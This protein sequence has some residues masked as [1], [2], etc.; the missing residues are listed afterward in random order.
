[1]TQRLQSWTFI[2][3]KW[4]LYIH[5]NSCTWMFMAASFQ[6]PKPGISPE[7]CLRVR[8]SI[9]RMPIQHQQ[10]ANCWYMQQLGRCTRE[11]CQAQKVTYRKV[12]F[13]QHFWND[14]ISQTEDKVVVTR[15]WGWWGEEGGCDSKMATGGILV[16]TEL[17]S[18]L[19]VVDA[20]TDPRIQLH[21]TSHA[22]THTCKG[23]QIQPGKSE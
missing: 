2:P 14:K 6:E 7:E 19:S 13:I 1:M 22:C 21:R 11:L 16:P 10:A 17:F 3:E 9:L 18:A 15:G 4:K 23:V 5:T 12:P 8:T 20:Q